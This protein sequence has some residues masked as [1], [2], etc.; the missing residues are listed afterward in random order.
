MKDAFGAPQSLLVL[1]GSSEIG[2]AVARRL[3]AD[4]TRRVVLAGRPSARLTA[5]AAELTAAGAT[6]EVIGFDATEPDTHAATVAAAFA[7]GDIDVVVLAAGVLGDQRRDERDVAAAVALA[8][9]NYVG[10]LSVLLH[11]AQALRRQG[12]GSLVV[13]STVAAERPRR[14]N[15]IYGSSKAGLDALAQGLGD[16]LHG[17]GVHVLVVRPGFVR[18]RMTA[19]MAPAPFATTAEQVADAVARALGRRT[20][21]IWVPPVLRVVLSVV[22]HL[23]RSVFRRLPL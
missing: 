8:Q 16:A 3:V 9:V 21:V 6:T 12:H 17:S 20:E 11:C 1:G 13:L 19:G 22:R 5:A 18:T 2:L 14:A 7:G 23:P 4:R 15:F 10:G